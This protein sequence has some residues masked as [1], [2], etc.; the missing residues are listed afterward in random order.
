VHFVLWLF[1]G[2]EG[3]PKNAAAGVARCIYTFFLPFFL[4]FPAK[5]GNPKIII[6]LCA[7]DAGVG[8]G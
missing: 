1:S 2:K 8:L 3:N 6:N 7:G 4:L 5:R